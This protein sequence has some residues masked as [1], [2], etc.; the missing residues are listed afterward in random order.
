M[1]I[2]QYSVVSSAMLVYAIAGVAS[3]TVY[4]SGISL[5]LREYITASTVSRATMAIAQ[6]RRGCSLSRVRVNG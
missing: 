1:R 2:Y 6:R 4:P 5:L 3:V